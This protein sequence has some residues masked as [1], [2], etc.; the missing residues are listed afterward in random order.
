MARTLALLALSSATATALR[1]PGS[2]A[3]NGTPCPPPLWAPQ[4]NF[5]LST[6]CQPSSPDYFVPPVDEPW[7][8]V[9]LDWS[10]AKSVWAKNGLHNGTIEA[11]SIEGCR[12]IKVNN[13]AGRCFIYHNMELALESMETQRLVMYDPAQANLFLQYTDGHGNKTGS[14]YNERQEP[15]DQFFWDFRVDAASSYYISSVLSTLA[16]P[17]VDGSFTDD[18]TGL[19][20]EHDSAPGNMKL[21]AEEVTDIQHATADTN[22]QLIAQA[23]NM[24]K[25]V[26]QAFGDQDGVNAGPTKADCAAWMRARCSA[27]YQD[28]AITQLF[29]ASNINQSIA[30]FLVTRPPIAYLGFGWESDQRQWNPAFRWAVGEPTPSGA[31]CVESPTNVF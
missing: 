17:F 21:S 20:A 27:S 13:P 25:Y 18:V 22:G 9:S 4:W 7:G 6:I 12:R 23:I 10:V 29:D 26:W 30:S 19:P 24:G 15:G 1:G 16:S 2:C 14:I 5:T 11:T 31:L 28:R 3:T 8:L